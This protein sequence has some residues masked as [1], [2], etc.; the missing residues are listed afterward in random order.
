MLP[1]AAHFATHAC[2]Q[3]GH[4]KAKGSAKEENGDRGDGEARGGDGEDAEI[5]AVI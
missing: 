2:T 5:T 1:Y 3:G 4:P